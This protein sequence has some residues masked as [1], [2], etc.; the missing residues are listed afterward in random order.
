V[1]CST[2][3]PDWEHEVYVGNVTECSLSD[4]SIDDL[5]FGVKAV[6]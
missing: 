6:D 1:W 4:V 3:A 5:V 2:T